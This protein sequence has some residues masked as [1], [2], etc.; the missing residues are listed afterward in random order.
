[1]LDTCPVENVMDSWAARDS[2]ENGSDSSGYDTSDCD[3]VGAL[4]FP[5]LLYSDSSSKWF[6]LSL[7]R[8]VCSCP[9][10]SPSW[11]VGLRLGSHSESVENCTSQL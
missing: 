6:F 3:P 5:W 8:A 9:I 11:I 1:M 4:I 10:L 2:V 7:L